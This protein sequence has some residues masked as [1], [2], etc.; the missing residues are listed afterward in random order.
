MGRFEEALHAAQQ[1]KELGVEPDAI[2]ADIDRINGQHVAHLEAMAEQL[3]PSIYRQRR[4]M[5][6]CG[7]E[8]IRIGMKLAS[9]AEV[10]VDDLVQ[11]AHAC[12]AEEMLADALYWM[13]K[14]IELKPDQ[15]E[16]LRFKASILERMGRFEGALQ[17]ANDARILGSD[18]ES[19]SFD[20]E[21]IE[22]QLVCHLAEVSSCL[23]TAASLPASVKLLCMGRLTFPEFINLIGKIV[24]AYAN[25]N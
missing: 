24:R 5:A 16:H 15:G 10:D 14:A 13:G 8:R 20:A 21:R 4:S 19:I 6:V 7:A 17:V 12:A 3:L 1:A 23:D 2:S 22:A 18:T 11:L 9:S 25:K